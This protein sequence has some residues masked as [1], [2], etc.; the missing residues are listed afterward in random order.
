MD[1]ESLSIR[2]E[3]TQTILAMGEL[4]ASHIAI[5][6]T[7]LFAYIS[8]AYVAGRKLSRLQLGVTTF[9]FLAASVREVSNI[10]MLGQA[11]FDMQSE[12]ALLNPE[13]IAYD[14]QSSPI[15]FSIW[16][17]VVV[18]STGAFAALVFMW[19]VRRTKSE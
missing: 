6:L 7:I 12:L 11:I 15:L 17:S 1:V 13:G 8:A 2:M 10:A 19:S 9:I 4:Q 18:W 14:A 3:M 5:Y 16:W